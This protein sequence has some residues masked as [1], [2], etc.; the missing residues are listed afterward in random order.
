MKMYFIKILKERLSLNLSII[1]QK[2]IMNQ[3]SFLLYGANGYTGQLII[4]QAIKKGISIILGGRTESKIKPLAEQ[5]SLPYRVFDLEDAATVQENI[6]DVKVVLHCAGPFMYTAKPMMTACLEMGVHYLD[7]TGEIAVFEMAHD[8]DAQAKAKGIMMMSGTGFDIVP[9]DCMSAFLKSEMPDATHLELA[10]AY[11]GGG[12]SRGTAITSI[13]SL[14]E[15][16]KIRKDGVLKS[17]P[18]GHKIKEIKFGDA[19]RSTGVTIPWGDVSTAF[20]STGIPNTEVFLGM[21]ASQIKNIKRSQYLGW[22]LKLRPVKNFLIKQIKKRPAGPNENRRETG[23]AFIRGE[24]TNAK[25]EKKSAYMKTP[26]GYKLTAFMAL[27]ITE[28]VLNDDFKIGFQTP[29]LAYGMDLV[30]EMDGTERF[31]E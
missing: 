5:Y 20:Y 14:G 17:V 3:P 12:I 1:T 11:K 31:L 2:R 28:K 19:F 13:E 21:K 27:N 22:L 18:V 25:G 4:P 26:E 8:F 10:F 30:L 23:T 29:S 6:K 7:I 24:V 15:E 9:T 16:G